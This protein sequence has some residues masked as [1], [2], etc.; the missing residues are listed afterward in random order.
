M[1]GF[2]RYK[3]ST[4]WAKTGSRLL[5][6]E[7]L[8]TDKDGADRD[9]WWDWWGFSS[10]SSGATHTYAG[11]GTPTFSGTGTTAY[12]AGS[13]SFSYS[14]SGTVAFTG[15][16]TTSQYDV[17]SYSGTGTVAFTGTATTN[18]VPPS[19]ASYSYAG[20]G[21]I[22][23]SGAATTAYA[24]PGAAIYAY[25]GA[26]SITLSGAATVT[27]Q[28]VFPCVGSGAIYFDGAAQIARTKAVTGSGSLAFSGAAL[29]QWVI[30]STDSE[31]IDLILNLLQNRQE[32]DP[33]A[34][35][36]TV[37]ADDGATILKSA[38]A[39]EDAAGT[40]PYS[41]KALRRIDALT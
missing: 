29:T 4:T 15:S 26:G 41:G 35:T 20:S 16:A 21:S 7:L 32:L 25:A 23:L 33:V 18:Y 8:P 36:F 9:I 5:Y 37:Y 38:L 6:R 12:I 1:A 24:P 39:W 40:I 13:G 17:R 30:P 14:G 11:S 2:G 34:G 28:R 27:R 19:G 31:K 22:T 3:F 10:S